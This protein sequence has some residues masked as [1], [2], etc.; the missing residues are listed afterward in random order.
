[1]A[2][3]VMHEDSLVEESAPELEMPEK[4]PLHEIDCTITGCNLG[5]GARSGN[6]PFPDMPDVRAMHLHVRLEHGLGGGLEKKFLEDPSTIMSTI[7]EEVKTAKV[8]L[9]YVMC[10]FRTAELKLSKSRQCSLSHLHSHYRVA[11]EGFFRTD[12]RLWFN[13]REETVEVNR[14]ETVT[15]DAMPSAIIPTTFPWWSR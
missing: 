3:V 4:V 6:L 13:R 1:M 14:M 2:L 15:V 10:L 11:R 5:P 9:Y 8:S 7:L 12:W